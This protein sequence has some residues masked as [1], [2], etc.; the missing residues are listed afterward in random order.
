MLTTVARFIADLRS[1]DER[2][3][4]IQLLAYHEGSRSSRPRPYSYSL[5][6]PRAE[7]I[8]GTVATLLEDFNAR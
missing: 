2:Q 1:D 5:S 8:R 3:Y 7:F 6:L 4:A